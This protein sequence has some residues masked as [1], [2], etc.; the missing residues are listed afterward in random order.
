MKE[1]TVFFCADDWGLTPSVSQRIED[2]DRAGKLNKISLFPNARISDLKER[3]EAF[4]ATPSLHLNLV[5]GDCLSDPKKIPLL[6]EPDGKFRYS[7]TGLLFHS[8]MGKKKEWEE[9][10]A[11]EIRAQI[12]RFRQLV[13]AEEKLFLDSHQHTPMSPLIFR[14]LMQVIREDQVPVGYLRIPVEPITPFCKEPGLYGTY[15]PINWIKQTLLR[16]LFWQNKGC[17][18]ESG[19]P[20]ALFFGILFSGSM[21]ENRVARILP[22][23]LTL[24]RKKQMDVELLFHPGVLEGTKE[25]EAMDHIRFWSFYRSAGRETEW[26]GLMHSP[27]LK[28]YQSKRGDDNALH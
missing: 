25:A 3:I 1:P 16:F 7:F 28:K 18:R 9:Q 11:I 5:E 21:D 27:Q 14:V 10:V 20:T 17:F 15:S 13:P 23:Y 24:A 4:S 2:C 26:N 19:I 22:H 12:A 6:A 8:I